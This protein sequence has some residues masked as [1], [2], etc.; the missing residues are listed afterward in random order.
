MVWLALCDSESGFKRRGGERHGIER[1]GKRRK[2][3]KI[4]R[5]NKNEEEICRR[6]RTMAPSSV[7]MTTVDTPPRTDL[8]EEVRDEFEALGDSGF[9]VVG[10]CPDA[11][12][13]VEVY[14]DFLRCVG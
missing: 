9:G 3:G 4:G 2:G 13:A 14:G 12:H 5:G 7:G 10:T 8:V 1:R 11:A 6:P